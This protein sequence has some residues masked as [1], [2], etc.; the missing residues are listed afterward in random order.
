MTRSRFVAFA[1]LAAACAALGLARAREAAAR[2]ETGAGALQRDTTLVFE[3]G[4]E[5]RVSSWPMGATGME[6]CAGTV[7][8]VR[9]SGKTLYAQSDGGSGMATIQRFPSAGTT[10]YCTRMARTEGDSVTFTFTRQVTD[11]VGRLARLT[12]GSHRVALAPLLRRRVTFRW[13]AEGVTR[14]RAVPA[15]EGGGAPRR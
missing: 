9:G 13:T 1:L 2:P 8:G 6:L 5:V 11:P 3:S 12:V 10:A 14:I 4:D 15:P 7:Q